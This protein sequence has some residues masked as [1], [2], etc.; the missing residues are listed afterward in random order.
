MNKIGLL[1]F[2]VVLIALC[3]PISALP[4]MPPNQF[5]GT[6]TIGGTPAPD[7]LIISARINGVEYANT[8]T[9]DGEY[10]VVSAF[11]LPSDNPDTP[12]KDGGVN[13]DTIEFYVEGVKAN[14]TGTF[15]WGSVRQLDLTVTAPLAKKGLPGPSISGALA[16]FA[17]AIA[18]A[19]V[20]ALL[21]VTYYKL[22]LKRRRKK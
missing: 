8:T 7:G 5:W 1:G 9:S 12:E 21:A 14:E 4:P 15:Q 10:G 2:L 18:I 17:L 20:I 22:V 3:A 11:Y 13:G 6:A 19:I 16:P